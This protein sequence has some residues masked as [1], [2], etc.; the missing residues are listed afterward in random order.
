MARKLCLNCFR[1]KENYEVCPYC[2][3]SDNGPPRES[4]ELRPG[5][6]LSNRYIIGEALGYGGFGITYRGYDT[7]MSIVV[8]IKEFYPAGLV[9]RAEGTA[10]VGVFSGNKTQQY[11]DMLARFIDEARNLALFQAEKN[12]VNVFSYFE[13]NGTAYIIMEYVDSPILGDY[14][15]AK[16]KL[17][18]EEACVCMDSVL[19]AVRKIHEKGIIHRDISPDNIFYL[20]GGHVK[21]FDFGAARLQGEAADGQLPPVV[22][23]GYTPPEQYRTRAVQDERT[24]IYACGALMYRMLTGEKPNESLDRLDKDRL[25]P[26][27]R[28]GARVSHSVDR[29]VMKALALDPEKRFATAEEFRNALDRKSVLPFGKR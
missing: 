19:E 28:H 29:A 21:I 18:Q 24:D 9:N 6:I 17:S 8:A 2:G 13:D 11:T 3:F 20:E 10:K 16:G 23:P 1:I 7:T 5:T 25:Q 14:L 26:P 27:S 4:F 22:K 12:V 15:K